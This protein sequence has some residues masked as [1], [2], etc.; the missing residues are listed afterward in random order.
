MPA[1][2]PEEQYMADKVMPAG[3]FLNHYYMLLY[4]VRFALGV[5]VWAGL[6]VVQALFWSLVYPGLVEDK[7]AQFTD[8][9]SIANIRQ[10]GAK[11]P[12]NS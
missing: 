2:K 3:M 10:D 5:S 7:L 12:L 1:T 6:A 8:I 4:A 11:N 9:C